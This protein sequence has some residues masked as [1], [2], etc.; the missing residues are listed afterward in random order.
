MKLVCGATMR[1]VIFPANLRMVLPAL[2]CLFITTL[3]I[4]FVSAKTVRV[5][6]T[7]LRVLIITGGHEFEREP[8][9]AMFRS[10]KNI[11]WREA[12]QPTANELYSPNEASEYDVLAL[13]DLVQEISEDQKQNLVR[14]LKEQGKGLV[15]LHHCIGNYQDWPEFRRILGGRYYLSKRLEGGVEYQAGQFLHDQRLTVQ[16]FNRLHPVTR[17]LGDFEIDDETYKGFYVNPGVTELLKVNHPESDPIIAWAHQ[18]GRSRVAYIQLGHGPAAYAHAG[19]R[20]LV[21]NA[22]YWVSG[23]SPEA[24]P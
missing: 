16:I 20:R 23:R 3:I 8:F 21:E 15:G 12:T 18:Y 19:Y 2:F 7:P 22:I 11:Q 1:K 24:D 9:F 6:K 13:Y 14:L 10:M 4:S 5:G 17:G